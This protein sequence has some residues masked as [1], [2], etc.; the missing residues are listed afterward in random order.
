MDERAG[1]LPELPC[2]GASTLS[3]DD[4]VYIRD[5]RDDVAV[6]HRVDVTYGSG[7]LDDRKYVTLCRVSIPVSMTR[8]T[9][10]KPSCV[11]CIGAGD[12]DA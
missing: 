11:E 5:E 8:W 1:E 2:D 3:S 6:V 12:R 4:L 10:D 9:S 7:N